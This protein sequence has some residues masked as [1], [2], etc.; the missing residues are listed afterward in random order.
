MTK[1][2]IALKI[3]ETEPVFK[4]IDVKRI[5]QKTL[6]CIIESL[7]N[8][9]TVELRNFGIFKIKSRRARKGRNPRTGTEVQ[10]PPKKVAVFKPGLIMKQRVK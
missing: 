7:A 1:K 10:V 3:S 4:Q 5:I 9:N 6:D 8:G 2:D